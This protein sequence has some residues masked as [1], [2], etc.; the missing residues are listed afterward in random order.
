MRL[1]QHKKEAYWFYRFLSIF[2]DDYVNPL[3]WTEHMRDQSLELGQLN[4]PD[5]KVI[6]VGSGTGFTTQ[7]IVKQVKSTNVTCVDQSPHQLAKAKEKPDLHGCTFVEGDA[8]NIPFPDN[9]FDRYV[10][11]GSIEYWPHPLKGV[12]ESYRVIKPG[13]VA[14]L[15][16]PLEPENGFARFMANAWMLFPKDKEYREWYEAAGFK[17]IKVR[18]IR[19]QWYRRKGEYGIAIAGVKPLTG[20]TYSQPTTTVEDEKGSNLQI[21]WRVL[22]GSLAGFIFIPIALLGYLGNAFR[23]N[24]R[25]PKQYQERLNMHQAIAMAAIL[26]FI[27]FVLWLIFK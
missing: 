9:A 21:F 14:L 13:G 10:S 5:Y 12:Q 19:P 27:I 1:I 25:M 23:K 17:N 26:G 4:N 16:G 11:A 15:I 2:Y 22:I 6:D 8:E 3:F 7:G 18:Y 24:P 20:T